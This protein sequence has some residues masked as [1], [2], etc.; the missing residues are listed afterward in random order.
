MRSVAEGSVPAVLAAAEVNRPIF[1]RSVGSGSKG[2]PLVGS[3]AEGLRGALSAGAPVIGLAGLDLDGHG[4]FL[5]DD[6]FGHGIS[7]VEVL[8]NAVNNLDSQ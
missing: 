6:G 3:I 2:A 8:L 4:G 5:G 1:L 7:M